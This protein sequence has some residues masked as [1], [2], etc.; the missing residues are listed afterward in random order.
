MRSA[1][2][3]DDSLLAQLSEAGSPPNDDLDVLMPLRQGADESGSDSALPL[4]TLALE[5]RL[6]NSA[7]R[8]FTSQST[9]S[10]SISTLSMKRTVEH[11][12]DLFYCSPYD[13]STWH[14]HPRAPTPQPPHPR[15]PHQAGRGICS[16]SPL[17][18]IRW[19][20]R[21]TDSK[22]AST[23]MSGSRRSIGSFMTPSDMSSISGV[24]AR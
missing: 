6:A 14:H 5:R 16:T 1:D 12:F 13:A 4:S 17:P 2:P 15:Q 8:S 10:R 11:S 23:S 19:T 3:K 24:V 20:V 22:A 9:A 7:G 18:F 21:S